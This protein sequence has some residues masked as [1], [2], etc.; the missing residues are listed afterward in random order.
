MIVICFQKNVI[1]GGLGDRI[2]GI[3]SCFVVAK[4]LNKPFYI[5]WNKEDIKK[6][7]NYN[8][9]DF[10]NLDLSKQDTDDIKRYVIIDTQD[11]LKQELIETDYENL[12]NAKVNLFYTN[13]EWSQY[14]FKNTQF[15]NENYYDTIFSVYKSLYEDILKPT[16]YL[17]EKINSFVYEKNNII[18]IQIRCGDR[19]MMCSN[20]IAGGY[21]RIK[22]PE[23]AI[24]KILSNIKDKVAEDYSEYNIFL[25]SDYF[26]IYKIGCE[27]FD[28]ER[29]IY[30]NDV[31]QHLDRDSITNDLSKTF[32]DNYILSQKTTKMYISSYSNFGRIAAL[33]S[34][35]DN[36]YDLNLEKCNLKTFVSN[37]ERIF[38]NE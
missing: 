16:D 15:T 30:I 14:L 31:I 29:I 4:L 12:F 23:R 1:A 24:R 26:N 17:I 3:V 36:I 27:F 11:V 13:Q 5:L 35:H 2:N 32:A 34:N 19:Y 20:G 18:G 25:T 37:K 10:E 7:I 21:V 8:D 38:E 28:K 6:C 33:S 22:D 9:Y